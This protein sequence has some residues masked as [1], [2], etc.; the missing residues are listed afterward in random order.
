MSKS[1][2]FFRDRNETLQIID[3]DVV[4]HFEYYPPLVEIAVAVTNAGYAGVVFDEKKLFNGKILL[5]MSTNQS[6]P[7]GQ[8]IHELCEAVD[9]GVSLPTVNSVL[10]QIKRTYDAVGERHE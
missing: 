10:C 7:E 4:P 3:P 1:I 5:V 8:V 2:V 9:S 6:T